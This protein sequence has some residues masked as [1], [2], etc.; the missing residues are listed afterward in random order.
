[1]NG[2]ELGEREGGPG[3]TTLNFLAVYIDSLEPCGFPEEESEIRMESQGP[4][5]SD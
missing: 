3:K 1:M 4:E 5:R 2:R